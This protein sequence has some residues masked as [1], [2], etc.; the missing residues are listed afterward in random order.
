MLGRAKRR[1]EI[2]T[3]TACHTISIEACRA[4]KPSCGRV[5]LCVAETGGP[6]ACMMVGAHVWDSVGAQSVGFNS[7]LITRAGNAPLTVP[8]LPQPNI[9]VPDLEALGRGLPASETMP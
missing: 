5:P 3:K 9:V 1:N 2:R 4:Y 7:A 8:G 6:S